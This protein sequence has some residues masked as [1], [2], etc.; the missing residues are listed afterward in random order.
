LPSK[1]KQG[2]PLLLGSELDG[3]VREY[4]KFL[5]KWGSSVNTAVVMGAGEGVVKMPIS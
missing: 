4:V 1:K 2:R 5:R 3:Q